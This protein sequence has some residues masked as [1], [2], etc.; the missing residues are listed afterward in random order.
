MSDSLF[1]PH[2][3]RPMAVRAV[4][5][6]YLSLP[7]AERANF[8]KLLGMD[9]LQTRLNHVLD[10]LAMAR[11]TV[12]WAVGRIIRRNREPEERSKEIARLADRL[13]DFGVS[14]ADIA[15]VLWD[16]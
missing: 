12:D 15:A 4:W 3:E 8:R 10:E 13:K 2:R 7:E 11:A 6:A 1:E 14:W 16:Q 9:A 5:E